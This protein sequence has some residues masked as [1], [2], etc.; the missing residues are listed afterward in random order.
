MLQFGDTLCPHPGIVRI[1][2]GA[3][4]GAQQRS[5]RGA[6]NLQSQAG[7]VSGNTHFT[8]LQNQLS[9][10][11]V[12]RPRP[13]LQQSVCAHPGD[14]PSFCSRVLRAEE[15]TAAAAATTPC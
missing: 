14:P 15:A 11:G 10:Q 2:R 5:V 8:V 4:C 7:P 6:S 13:S 1:V 9:E 3:A 12:G